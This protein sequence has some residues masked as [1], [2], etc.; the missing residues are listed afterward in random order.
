MVIVPPA[1]TPN[2]DSGVL[3]ESDAVPVAVA[4]A[5]DLA[6]LDDEEVPALL[7]DE[8]VVPFSRFS[9]AAASWELVRFSAV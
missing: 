6:E 1:R 5:A 3:V 2:S 9:M 8:P 4:A 7:D